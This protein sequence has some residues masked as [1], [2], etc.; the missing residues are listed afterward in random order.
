MGVRFPSREAVQTRVLVIRS[1]GVGFRPRVRIRVTTVGARVGSE[2]GPPR[3]EM[4]RDPSL[5][6]TRPSR[7]ITVA[8]AS[9]RRLRWGH[10]RRLEARCS[11]L[12]TSGSSPQGGGRTKRGGRGLGPGGSQQ[13]RRTR[14]SGSRSCPYVDCV[15]EVSESPSGPAATR[16]LKRAIDTASEKRG[17]RMRV[18]EGPSIFDSIAA[19]ASDER[20]REKDDDASVP[21]Q[22]SSR[23][24]ARADKDP[25]VPA[26]QGAA[27]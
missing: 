26:P 24:R 12:A 7:F 27:W 23:E 20:E 4:R 25:D 15:A 13:W 8:G 10:S 2:E 5:E 14:S 17:V 16:L 3:R 19:K 9:S 22:S 21:A 11:P 6:S 1:S 18:N